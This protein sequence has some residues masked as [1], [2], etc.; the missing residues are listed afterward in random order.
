MGVEQVIGA[1][2]TPQFGSVFNSLSALESVARVLV[3][4]SSPEEGK[5]TRTRWT[6]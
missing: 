3:E 1:C 4:A 5:T 2:V 6:S